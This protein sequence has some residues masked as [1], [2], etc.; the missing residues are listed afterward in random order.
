M[1]EL[2][3]ETNR[4]FMESVPFFISMTNEQKNSIAA[5]LV[6]VK[7]PKNTFIVN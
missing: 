2:E 4:V 3:Y 6:S 7:Y 1:A 5:N